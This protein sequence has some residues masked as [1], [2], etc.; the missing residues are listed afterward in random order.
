MLGDGRYTVEWFNPASGKTV[1]ASSV[2]GGDKR[3]TPPFRGNAVLYL[4]QTVE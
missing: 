1:R 3:F 4:K 2:T